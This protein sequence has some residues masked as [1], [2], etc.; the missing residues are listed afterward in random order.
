MKI[1]SK[2]KGQSVVELVVTL[3][4]LLIILSL[5]VSMGLFIYD[6]TVMQFAANKGLDKAIGMYSGKEF[7]QD[8]INEIKNDM[9]NAYNI[10][11]FASD[12]ITDASSS[13][14]TGQ[15]TITVKISSKFNTDAPLVGQ[16]FSKYSDMAV[17]NS[18][19]IK[20]H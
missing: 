18:F 6:K 15:T 7:T 14:E 2:R 3:P 10:K 1:N 8:E 17:T 4:L 5:I 20:D 16:L 12:P 13:D 19:V 9:N 11:V